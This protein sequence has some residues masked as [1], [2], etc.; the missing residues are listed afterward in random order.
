MASICCCT[1]SSLARVSATRARLAWDCSMA[2]SRSPQMCSCWSTAVQRRTMRRFL[3]RSSASSWPSSTSSCSDA[4]STLARLALISAGSS[5]VMSSARISV[6]TTASCSR[7]TWSS[8]SVEETI[9]RTAE[10]SAGPFGAGPACPAG[11]AVAAR[12][13]AT[14]AFGARGGGAPVMR[15]RRVAMS[16]FGRTRRSSQM[17]MMRFTFSPTLAGARFTISGRTSRVRSAKLSHS[18]GER[19]RAVCSTSFSR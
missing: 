5:T 14:A 7:D 17:L 11:G 2:A 4:W 9:F 18:S 6:G 8:T 13:T 15:W 3:S 1:S 19:R 10:R 12:D 16:A